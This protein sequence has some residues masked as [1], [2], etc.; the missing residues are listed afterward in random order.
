MSAL[1]SGTALLGMAIAAAIR[2]GV[3]WTGKRVAKK[4]APWLESPMGPRGFIGSEFHAQFAEQQ[5]L[6]ILAPDNHGLLPDFNA[7]RGSTFNPD[8]V[9]PEVRDFYEHTA[10]YTQETWTEAPILTR[11]FLWGL[12]T[13]VSRP[14]D[15]LNFPISPLDMAAG[16]SNEILPLENANGE[17]VATGWLRRLESDGRVIYASFYSV[18]CTAS[19]LEPCIK[20]S[21]PLPLGCSTVFLRPAAQSDGSLKLASSG[22]RFG[23]SG[24]YRMV[25]TGPNHWRVRYI[26]ALREF[27]HFH[28]DKQGVLR[29]EHR[30]DFLGLTIL[31]MHYKL[32]RR[33]D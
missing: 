13:F 23:D 25:E 3:R 12:S 1:K 19:S 5:N 10:L 21:L 6:R 15:Q 24:F 14:M 11:F 16:M 17:H 18:G 28:V 27:F 30:I 7:L 31:R 22:S 20:V 32:Q 9:C 29:T 26:R 4:D 33:T 2:M 8:A